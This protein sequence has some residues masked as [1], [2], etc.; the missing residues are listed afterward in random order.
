MPFFIF[1]LI[2]FVCSSSGAEWA[3]LTRRKRSGGKGCRL[4]AGPAPAARRFAR[5]FASLR[6]AALREYLVHAMLV[7]DLNMVS[8]DEALKLRFTKWFG[9]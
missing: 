9:R 5:V 8:G 4:G 1:S 3:L 7:V 2:K 6:V